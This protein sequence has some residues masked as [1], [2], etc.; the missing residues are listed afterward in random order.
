MKD[1]KV[2]QYNEA[3]SRKFLESKAQGPAAD[4]WPDGHRAGMD[5]RWQPLYDCPA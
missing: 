1:I 2:C 5:A 3:C 4:Y